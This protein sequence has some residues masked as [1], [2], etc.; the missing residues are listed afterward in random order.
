MKK[1]I[2]FF[3]SVALFAMS[4]CALAMTTAT[5]A[6]FNF[7]HYHKA[8]LEQATVRYPDDTCAIRFKEYCLID[9]DGDGKAEVWVRG[10]DCHEYQ[11]VFALGG[12]SV[13][14]LAESD[15]YSE[16]LF[17]KGAVSFDGFYGEGRSIR[18]ASKIKRSCRVTTYYE[19][20]KVNAFAENEVVEYEKYVIDGRKATALECLRFRQSLGDS[21][22][23]IHPIW[24]P[25]EVE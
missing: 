13:A 23:I 1:K 18:G 22:H 3:G 12:D 14:L 4:F 21:I 24:F 15:S 11:G 6:G 25:V 20:I 10:D 5:S 19:E 2:T 8:M 9:I 7:G 16:L 17:H